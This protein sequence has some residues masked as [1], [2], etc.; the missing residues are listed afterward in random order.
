MV[1]ISCTSDRRHRCLREVA[2]SPNW[3]VADHIH[4]HLACSSGRL[5]HAKD[6]LEGLQARATRHNLSRLTP[7]QVSSSAQVWRDRGFTRLSG[8]LGVMFNMDDIFV[9]SDPVFDVTGPCLIRAFTHQKTR[10]QSF[11][12]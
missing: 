9:L 12:L 5:G 6:G 1:R 2:R 7:S 3:E 8:A 11:P 4:V 10:K